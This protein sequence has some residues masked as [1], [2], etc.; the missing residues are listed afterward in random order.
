MAND[1]PILTTMRFIPQ[2]KL[3]QKYGAILPNYLT[4]QAMKESKAYKTYYDFATGKAIPKPK[5]VRRSTKEKTKQAP[6]ASL[7]KRIKSAAKVTRSGKKKQIDEGLETL[8]EIA[9]SKAKQMK[10][11]IERSKTQLH[12]S[13]PSGSGAHEGT[14][15]IPGVADVPTYESDDEQISWESSDDED[16]DDETSVSKDEVDNDQE[17]DDDQG[18]DDERIDSDNEDDVLFILND[19]DN[20]KE[21]H[22]VNVKGDKLDEDETNEKD[23]GD[24]LYRDVNSSY[25]PS[26]FVSNMLNPSPNTGIDFIFNLNTKSTSLVDVPVTSTTE[27]PLL[28]A[29]TLLSPPTPLITQMQQTPIPTSAN[30]PSSSLQDLPNFGSLFG[31]DH[32]LKT[33]EI[34]FLEFK[35]TNQFVEVVSSILGIS[36]SYLAN[37]M[38]EAIKKAVQ[39]QSNRLRDEAQAENKDF[40]NK[41]D[42]NIK[43]IIKDQ[44]KE[45]VKAQVSKIL[46]KIKKTINEQ[47][48]AEVLTRSSNASKTSHVVAANLSELELKKILIGKMES[49]KSIH[50]SDEQKNLYKALVD[51]YEC[52]KLILDT[53]GDTVTFK[54]RRDDEDKD[55]EPSTRSNRG[56]KRRRARK[57]PEST[58]A[59]KEKTSKSNGKSTEGSKSHHKSASESSQAEEPVH[60][61]KDLEEPAHRE[62]KTGVTEEPMKRPLNILTAGPTFELMKGSYKS[63]VE[64]EYLFEEVYKATTD[65]LEWNN[66][67]G[68][69]YSHDL[70]KPLPLIPNSR[71][72]HVIPFD[73]FIN[74]DLEYLSGGV[75]SQKYTTSVIKTK[76]ADYRHLKWIEDLVPNRMESARDVYSKRRIIA[77]TDL[78]IVEWHNN[79]HLDWIT[80]RR[81]DDKL[82][83]ED[84]QLG[85]KSYQ[86]KINLTKPDTY[87]PNLKRKEAYTAYSNPRGFIYQNKDTKNR[88]MRSD[89]LHKFSDGTLNDVR[90]ALVDRLKGIRM[91]YLP[92][93]IWRRSDKDKARAMI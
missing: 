13:Q 59:P 68:Q 76:A 33:L 49:N 78:Q 24:E 79:K 19:E 60:T 87:I 21:I 89:E 85:V 81:D 57:E 77:V 5:Y 91:Q 54:R 9:L 55:K 66:P 93:T 46:P 84:L 64:L 67:E 15:V 4:T 45:Q 22:G 31:F 36:D 61:A 83:V 16:D 20:D 75:S 86:K 62:F 26:G 40:I 1:D 34:N 44:V 74:N 28:S 29:T 41:L 73:H 69:Q 58:S 6:K 11:A 2:H 12:I 8:S 32:R 48:E 56:S 50:I 23:E 7:G 17:D 14:G 82:L 63:L 25:V 39:L 51:A 35:Q 92:Q 72:R 53:Y 71:G 70:E 52:D 38:N 47:L 37:K 3:I 18:D 27:P 90:T 43:K 30:V 65:Q 80:V 88:L 10:L 42:D